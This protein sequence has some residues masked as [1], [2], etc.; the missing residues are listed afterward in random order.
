MRVVS[1]FYAWYVV[2]CSCRRH[3]RIPR[4]VVAVVLAPSVIVSSAMDP[5]RPPSPQ[6]SPTIG[7]SGETW[8][9][10]MTAYPLGVDLAN[11]P[12]AKNSYP[13]LKSE[14][15]SDFS[16]G[17]KLASDLPLARYC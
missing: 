6:S 16:D 5:P 13:S 3:Q 15:R 10:T 7:A 2:V 14:A 11:R 9:T 12:L 4:S 17:Y 1:L 8:M